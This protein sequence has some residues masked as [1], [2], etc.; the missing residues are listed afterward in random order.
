MPII[1]ISRKDDPAPKLHCRSLSELHCKILTNVLQSTPIATFIIDSNHVVTH[2]NLAC[3]I[4]TGVP[5]TEVLGTNKAWS[6]FYPHE[7]PTLADLV[8]DGKPEESTPLYQQGNLSSSRTIPGAFESEGFFPFCGEGK[9][10]YFTAAPITDNENNIIGVIET[11]QD[12]T[13]RKNAEKKAHRL[14]HFDDLTGLPNRTSFYERLNQSISLAERH[15]TLLA[16]GF[17]DLDGFKNINDTYG[18]DAGDAVLRNVAEL[19]VQNLRP[20]DTIARM[21]GDEFAFIL[22]DLENISEAESIF[23]RVL[24]GI[25]S[26]HKGKHLPISASIGFSVYGMHGTNPDVLLQHADK[27]MYLIKKNKKN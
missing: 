20:Y 15:S 6:G 2:W 3:E 23:D 16:I 1:N 26:L 12:I 25:S 10:L 18:H 14:A 22:P 17:M 13:L 5:S 19:S 11:L 27:T 24:S 4:I 7:R 9:W 21:G 8:L